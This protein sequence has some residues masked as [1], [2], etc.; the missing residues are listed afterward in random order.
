MS[1]LR[2]VQQHYRREVRVSV[3]SHALSRTPPPRRN[4]YEARLLHTT[5]CAMQKLQPL[6]SLL[7]QLDHY[8]DHRLVLRALN[9]ANAGLDGAVSWVT[10]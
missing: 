2:D 1:R 4:V 10:S 8:V 7:V 6:A 3:C 5:Q 9:L